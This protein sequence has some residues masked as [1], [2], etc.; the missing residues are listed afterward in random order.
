MKYKKILSLMMVSA[1][2][3][4]ALETF[5]QDSVSKVEYNR[6]DSLQAVYERDEA[7]TQKADDVEKMNDA[8]NEQTE[9][10][11]KAKEAQRIEEEADDAA[12]QSK[13][14]LKAEKK[15][16]KSR[17]AATKQAEKAEAARDKSDLN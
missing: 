9:T 1:T 11:A 13:N 6:A 16:Q 3:L 15:A 5:A 12:K 4:F 17:K 2:S 10:K 7:Q 14:A 8:K